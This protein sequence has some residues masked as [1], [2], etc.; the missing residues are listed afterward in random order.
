[1][2]QEIKKEV[3]ID[4]RNLGGCHRRKSGGVVPRKKDS[5]EKHGIEIEGDPKLAEKLVKEWNPEKCAKVDT[6][7]MRSEGK[8]STYFFTC[9]KTALNSHSKESE[10]SCL[11]VK[12][13]EVQ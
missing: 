10:E 9:I 11:T 8:R 7:V 3:R 2:E 12:L 13:A 6:P 5:V 1:M 4:I